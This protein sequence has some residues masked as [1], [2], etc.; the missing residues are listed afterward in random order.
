[1][2]PAV[3]RPV[4]R[5]RLLQGAG[6]VGAAAA[7]SPLLSA[8]SAAL[9]ATA[10]AQAEVFGYGVASGDPTD[11]AVLLWTRVNPSPDATPGSGVG[12]AV[13]VVWEV[14]G[15]EDFATVL[16]TGT[17]TTDAARDHTVK[18]DVTGLATYTRYFFRFRALGA[19]SP[20]GRTQTAPDEPGTPHAL[21]F[22]FTSCANWTGGYFSP[23]RHLAARTDLDFVLE[24]GDYLYEYGNGADRYGPDELAG[25]RDHEPAV[26]MTT[27][28]DY[29]LRHALYKSDPDLQAAH[30]A[31]PWIVI[32]DDHEVTN[33]TWRD[34][35]ENHGDGDVPDEGDFTTRRRLAYQAYLEWM[36]IRLPDQTGAVGEFRFW[37]R[38]RFGDLADLHVLETRQNRDQQVGMTDTAELASPDRHLPEP[39]QLDWL[40]AGLAAKAQQWHLVGNQTVVAPVR[41]PP[42]PGV[43]LEDM[44]P[45]LV[46]LPEGGPVFNADQWDG[47]QADQA[48]LRQAMADAGGDPVVL[49]GDIHSSW[50]N[51][52]P[53]DAGT[54]APS[55]AAANNS[56]GV[57]FVTPSVTSDGFYEIFQRNEAAAQSATTG[58][59][60]SNRH[61]RFLEGIHHG[62]AVHDVTPEQVQTD[63]VYVESDETPADPRLDPDAFAV[64]GPSWRSL[65][66]TRR[67]E[68]APGPVGARSDEPRSAAGD[69]PEPV[70]PEVPA[71][72][73]LPL[74]AAGVAVAGVAVS[75]RTSAA[76]VGPGDAAG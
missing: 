39:E 4:G 24:L 22:A 57:E 25:E 65:A 21:R 36:P 71:A 19:T 73:L 45:N 37:R 51:D 63:W 16:R 31:F 32:F 67:V 74:A 47:Y 9:A 17:V 8:R 29:R 46:P 55:P 15:T 42:T 3:A 23:Y 11:S 50:A 18:V 6:V 27:L 66:G 61:V 48:R 68:E 69:E 62:F 7:L 59:Q 70:V 76:T 2:P 72:V 53:L 60:A 34:G 13:D 30:A 20:V 41:F 33:D 28:T 40:V 35:A 64:A 10:D 75:R 12:P 38:F 5:R 49:T 52:L 43:P 56:V 58:F 26:E 44:L 1:M 14:S 54:Y